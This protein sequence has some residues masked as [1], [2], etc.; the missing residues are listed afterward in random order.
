MI[1]L[2]W[3]DMRTLHWTMTTTEWARMTRSTMRSR[4][5]VLV[6]WCWT[7]SLSQKSQQR[8]SSPVSPAYALHLLRPQTP[9]RKQRKHSDQRIRWSSIKK[10]TIKT[11]LKELPGGKVDTEQ[12]S[13]TISPLATKCLCNVAPWAEE[14]IELAAS[15]KEEHGAVFEGSSYRPHRPL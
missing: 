8:W 14:D 7:A 10:V 2:G 3:M 5:A 12:H 4:R 1:A 15:L 6:R 13:S 9:I 11:D